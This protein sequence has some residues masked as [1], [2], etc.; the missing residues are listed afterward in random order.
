[1]NCCCTLKDGKVISL[2]GAHD[3]FVKPIRAELQKFSS[4]ADEIWYWTMHGMRRCHYANC[5]HNDQH[6]IQK[7]SSSSISSR[8]PSEKC[9]PDQPG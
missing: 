1:M 7:S 5:D 6:F 8:I 9:T 4:S 2:C 3:D